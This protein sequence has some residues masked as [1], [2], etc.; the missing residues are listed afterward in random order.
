MSHGKLRHDKD[1]LNCGNEVVDKFCPN[2][3]Q[4]NT[5]T[6]QP[7]YFL[8]TH[9]IED[10]THYDGQFWST[11]KNLFF[12]PGKLTN[13]YLIGKRQR[14]VPPV[15]LYIF[16]SFITFFLFSFIAPLK[17]NESYTPKDDEAKEVIALRREIAKDIILDI[18]GDV[19][20]AGKDSLV[21]KKIDSINA[22]LND[23]IQNINLDKDWKALAGLDEKMQ[24]DAEFL[25]YT[26]IESYNKGTKNKIAFLS[27][28]QDPFA[29]KYF[30]LKKQGV[31][32]GDILKNLIETSF[33]NLPKALFIYLPFFAFLL[34]IFHSKKKWWYFDHGVFTLHYF[35]FLLL[36][37]LSAVILNR[38]VAFVNDIPIFAFII[39]IVNTLIILYCFV[40]FFIAHHRVYKSSRLKSILIGCLLMFINSIAFSFLLAGLALASF[41][42]MR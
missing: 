4:E 14:F 36:I 9:F 34:W 22:I 25:G 40:Y 38:L 27:W 24:Q 33:H 17:V 37:T 8:I 19:N 35:S 5:E 41:I 18:K 12:V 21:A 10:F 26:S 23:T 6:K 1:C 30:E 16:A 39:N 28:L 2:C 13:V 15:K 42:T 31:K 7:F 20:N 11:L 32:K 29:K 3:G